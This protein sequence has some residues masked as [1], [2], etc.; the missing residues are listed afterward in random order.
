MT[1]GVS[2]NNSLPGS[3]AEPRAQRLIFCKPL[4]RSRQRSG[5]ARLNKQTVLFVDNHIGYLTQPA[6]DDRLC[7]R[8]VFEQLCGRAKKLASVTRR[9]VRRSEYVASVETRRDS[10]VRDAA[11]KRRVRAGGFHDVFGFGSSVPVADE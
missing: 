3:R 9:N 11:G 4:N 5:V 8:H 2:L 7:H 6:R 1:P 10:L